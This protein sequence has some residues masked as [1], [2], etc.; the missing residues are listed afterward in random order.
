MIGNKGRAT[1]EGRPYTGPTAR[2]AEYFR[3]YNLSFLVMEEWVRGAVRIRVLIRPFVQ[4]AFMRRTL[5]FLSLIL[6]SGCGLGPV[7]KDVKALCPWL[8]GGRDMTAM[9]RVKTVTEAGKTFSIRYIEV[10]ENMGGKAKSLFSTGDV[11]EIVTLFVTAEKEGQLVAVCRSGNDLRIYA[12]A[13]QKQGIQQVLETASKRMPEVVRGTGDDSP[14]L[15]V[16]DTL[17]RPWQTYR[18]RWDGSKFKMERTVLYPSR[19]R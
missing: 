14:V 4:E 8:A 2:Q 12:Y 1:T 5:A 7:G 19:F 16:T 15:L 13:A 6:L 17:R 9:A 18:W 10:I 11:G 3:G